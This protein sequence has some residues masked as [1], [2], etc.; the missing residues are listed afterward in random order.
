MRT[1]THDDA[2]HAKRI[3]AV[4]TIAL[5]LT[6]TAQAE[7]TIY[8]SDGRVQGRVTTDSQ[9][10][11]MIYVRTG[12]CRAALRPTARAPRRSTT[13]A[14]ARLAASPQTIRT[15]AG[16]G[17]QA[18]RHPVSGEAAGSPPMRFGVGGSPNT[19]QPVKTQPAGRFSGLAGE[20][21]TPQPQ[22]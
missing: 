3:V 8:G 10:S 17:A 18:A 2:D 12:A 7:R 6:T 4:L 14:V 16:D 22:V 13:R 9:G 1:D 15:S 19:G 5:L 11:T 21:C 20:P